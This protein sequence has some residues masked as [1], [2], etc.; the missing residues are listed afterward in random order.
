MK[1]NAYS[2]S[3]DPL[4]C[5]AVPQKSTV[6]HHETRQYRADLT[7][8]E[9]IKYELNWVLSDLLLKYANIDSSTLT[10]QQ[11][12]HFQVDTGNMK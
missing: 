1:C 3:G 8:I 7:S 6:S 10:L 5:F 9:D 2:I 4:Y 11:R 12:N